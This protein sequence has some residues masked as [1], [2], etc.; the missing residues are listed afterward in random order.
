MQGAGTRKARL[1]RGFWLGALTLEKALQAEKALS[2]LRMTAYFT[3]IPGP[4]N[5]KWLFTLCP[6]GDGYFS[7][8]GF[9]LV[10]LLASMPDTALETLTTWAAEEL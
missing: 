9:E 5:R 2:T 8:V 10:G 3:S 6:H 7:P 1:E 4:G